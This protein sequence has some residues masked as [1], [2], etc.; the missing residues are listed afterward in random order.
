MRR[1]INTEEVYKC[2]ASEG[3]VINI[4][5]RFWALVECTFIITEGSSFLLKQLQ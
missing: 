3:P 2:R 4:F 1:N 5:I